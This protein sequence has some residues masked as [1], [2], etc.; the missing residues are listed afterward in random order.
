[1]VTFYLIRHGQK[2]TLIGDPPLSEIGKKQAKH[3]AKYLKNKQIQRIFASPHKRTKETANIIARELGLS[4]KLDDRLIERMNWG[5]KRGESFEEFWDEWQKTDLNRDYQP[6]HGCSSKESGRRL[7]FFLHDIS[8]GLNNSVI[9]VV[10]HGGTIGDLLRNVFSEKDLPLATNE[11]S[12]ARYVEIL[13]CSITTIKK[14]K[15]FIL[16]KIG[17]ITHLPIPLV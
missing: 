12:K 4:V 16:E 10:T 8:S 9:L 6:S 14:D 15:K 7:E 3:T 2:E 1:M 5:D 13:E 17:D 11:I